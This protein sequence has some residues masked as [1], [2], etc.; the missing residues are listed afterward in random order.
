MKKDANK[1]KRAGIRY[2]GQHEKSRKVVRDCGV[3]RAT[4]RPH[5]I[6]SHLRPVLRAIFQLYI[7]LNRPSWSLSHFASRK[8]AY[9][10]EARKRPTDAESW[11]TSVSNNSVWLLQY[12]LQA[13]LALTETEVTERPLLV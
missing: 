9:I 13:C 8:T 6:T 10:R 2:C 7:I 5:T 11:S 1:E 3:H 12:S 4:K